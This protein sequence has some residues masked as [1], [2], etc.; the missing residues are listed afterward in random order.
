MANETKKAKAKSLAAELTPAKAIYFADFSKITARDLTEIRRK[1]KTQAVKLTVVKNRL[2]L[3]VLKELT[4][5]DF[6]EFLKGQ[7]ALAI[8]TD[9]P[10]APA[11]IM[12]GFPQLKVKGAFLEEKIFTKE[13]F[14]FLANLPTRE[15]LTAELLN[16]MLGPVYNLIYVLDGVMSNLVLT[17]GAMKE[18]Q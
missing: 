11:R 1:M 8:S 9:D 3:R 14:K 4:D 10:I 12:K 15:V 6:T 5:N 7:T 13:E 18:A 17:L 2:A 16:G